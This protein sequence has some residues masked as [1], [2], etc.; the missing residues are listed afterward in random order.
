MAT[1]PGAPL[2]L[3][4]RG[5]GETRRYPA[6]ATI[7]GQP[8]LVWWHSRGERCA[9]CQLCGYTPDGVRKCGKPLDAN[10][11][12]NHGY[13]PAASGPAVRATDP[14]T[15]RKAAADVAVRAGSQRWRLLFAYGGGKELTADEAMR[16]A[17]VSERSCYWKRI[18]ELVQGG[19]LEDTGV[20]RMGEQGSM[21]RVNK[22]TA[23]GIGVFS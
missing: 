3:T 7:Q 11:G 5:C 22:I 2:T 8:A 13:F 17:G 15:S 16:D 10:H 23:K 1:V 4:C 6:S 14:A 20:E 9:N 18:S 21:Q 19:Y 12:P